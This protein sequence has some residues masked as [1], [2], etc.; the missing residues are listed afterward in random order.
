MPVGFW[1]FLHLFSSISLIACMMSAYWNVLAARRVDDWGRRFAL[2]EATRRT[3]L[4]FGLSSV[5]LVGVF[6][7]L[8][9]VSLGLRLA[10]DPWVRWVDGLWFATVVVL[11]VWTLPASRALVRE[12]RRAVE[13]GPSNTFD[14]ALDRWRFSNATLVLLSVASIGL[15]VFRWR[16]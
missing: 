9:A 2:F 4:R 13:W 10:T 5:L 7:N 8:T 15:M 11:A 14:R 16:N 3:S 12:A 6:A 1:K